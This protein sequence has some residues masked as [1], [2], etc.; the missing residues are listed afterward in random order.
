MRTHE[1]Y[2]RGN[3]ESRPVAVSASLRLC[4]WAGACHWRDVH[5]EQLLARRLQAA[6]G[7]HCHASNQL[8]TKVPVFITLSSQPGAVE[9][10]RRGRLHRAC[11]KIPMIR[12]KQPRPAQGISIAERLDQDVFAARGL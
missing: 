1:S 9:E 12:R 8:E 4:L 2:R 10:N 7:D 11:I 6:D 3:D 5:R